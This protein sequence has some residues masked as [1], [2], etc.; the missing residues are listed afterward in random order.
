MPKN[1]QS[2]SSLKK[3]LAQNKGVKHGTVR[4]GRG[5]RALRRYNAK[6]G[7]WN[8]VATT[9]RTK[10]VM[11]AKTRQ[12][13]NASTKIAGSGTDAVNAS[14]SAGSARTSSLAKSA[15]DSFI[16]IPRKRSLLPTPRLHP[17]RTLTVNRPRDFPKGTPLRLQKDKSGQLRYVKVVKGRG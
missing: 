9:G 6:T 7:R 13:K 2:K 1:V 15:T 16:S 12:V 14:T 10:G 11:G 5:G 4:T 3:R 8:I 17:P